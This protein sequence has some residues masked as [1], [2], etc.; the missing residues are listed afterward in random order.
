M[1]I[2]TNL[3]DLHPMQHSLTLLTTRSEQPGLTKHDQTPSDHAEG[4]QHS[5]I[6]L[7]PRPE[8]TLPNSTRTVHSSP[9]SDN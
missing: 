3:K 4:D 7:N 1:H 8:P 6:H 9:E 5:L 2:P